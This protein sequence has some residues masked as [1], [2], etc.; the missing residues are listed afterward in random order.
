M[1]NEDRGVD[2]LT[3]T[4]EFNILL[5]CAAMNPFLERHPAQPK[6]AGATRSQENYKFQQEL[7][8]HVIT[9]MNKVNGLVHSL[10]QRIAFLVFNHVHFFC[11]VTYI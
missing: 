8:D 2:I 3:P 10:T 5:V 11:Y 1:Q 7:Q 4:L 6:A 9:A